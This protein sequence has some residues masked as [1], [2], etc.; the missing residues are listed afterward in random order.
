MLTA[1]ATTTTTTARKAGD[2]S[3][4]VNVNYSVECFRYKSE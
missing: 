4:Y 3:N 1:A 2:N